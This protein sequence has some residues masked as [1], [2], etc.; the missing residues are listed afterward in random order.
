MKFTCSSRILEDEE[1][2]SGSEEE[3]FKKRQ[4][5]IICIIYSS[6]LNE[7]DPSYA[8]EVYVS[9]ERVKGSAYVFAKMLTSILSTLGRF[10]ETKCVEAI[11]EIVYYTQ[12]VEGGFNGF[13][14]VTNISSLLKYT[15][16]ATSEHKYTLIWDKTG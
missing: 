15:G 10:M 1:S 7:E 3:D 8:K 4:C 5:E 6:E 12:G 2:G 13:W 16:E 11:T 9:V 14:D